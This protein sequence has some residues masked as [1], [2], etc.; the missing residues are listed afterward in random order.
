MEVEATASDQIRAEL[1]RVETAVEAGS[2]DLKA[3]GFWGIVNRVKPDR[4]LVEEHADQIGRID[5]RAFRAGVKFRIP[6]WAGNLLML[7]GVLVGAAGVWVAF[8]A[9]TSWI[10]GLAL[11]VAGCAWSVAFHCPAHWLVGRAIGIRF[12]D[13]FLGGPP[14]PRPA[15]KT[16]Y[17]SYLRADPFSRSWFHAA[18]AIVTKI[19]PFLALAFWPASGAP[20]WSAI[21]LAVLGVGQI[22]TDLRFSTKTSDWMRFARER[23]LARAMEPSAGTEPLPAN[24]AT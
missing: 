11:V 23:R 18:G 12:T 21:V 15:L 13:Y 20:G 9:D 5:T 4:L 7:V 8:D 19:A 10:K 14:P 6:V 22:L 16:D 2:A 17:A 1:D 3:L 24:T